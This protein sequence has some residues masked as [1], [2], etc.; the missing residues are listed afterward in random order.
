MTAVMT[1]PWGRPLTA[2]DYFALETPDDGR[3]CE[4]LDGCSS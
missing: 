1:L 2:D 3:R 4:L